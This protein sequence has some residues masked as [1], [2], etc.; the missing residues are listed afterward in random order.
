MGALLEVGSRGLTFKW[1]AGKH[2]PSPKYW[3]KLVGYILDEARRHRR[4]ASDRLEAAKEIMCKDCMRRYRARQ[5]EDL[6]A[7][8]LRLEEV[9][10]QM[11]EAAKRVG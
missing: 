11:V 10:E 3:A 9:R 2:K 7:E 8:V 1:L 6:A 5:Y 4:I